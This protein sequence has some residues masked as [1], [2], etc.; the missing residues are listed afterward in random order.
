MGVDYVI[1][2][3]NSVE[4]YLSAVRISVS[5]SILKHGLQTRHLKSLKKIHI[6]E[7]LLHQNTR[8]STDVNSLC[9]NLLSA[10]ATIKDGFSFKCNLSGNLYLNKNIFTLLILYLAKQKSFFKITQTGG[11]LLIHLDG[12]PKDVSLLVTALNGFFFFETKTQKSLIVIPTTES[13]EKSVEIET[14]WE[15]LFNIFSV[16]NMVFERI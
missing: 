7:S 13:N 16:L 9:T 5:V 10:V 12:K 4:R 2:L 3:P 11:F 14:E 15:Y 6:A 1:V 8:Q